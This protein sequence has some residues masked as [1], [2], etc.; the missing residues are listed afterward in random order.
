MRAE[1]ADRDDGGDDADCDDADEAD[2]ENV[3]RGE[4]ADRDQQ[5]Q[6]ACSRCSYNTRTLGIT[7]VVIIMMIN[8]HYNQ[9]SHDHYDHNYKITFFLKMMKTTLAISESKY[10]TAMRRMIHSFW[11]QIPDSS[12]SL[13]F[14]SSVRELQDVPQNVERLYFW[15]TLDHPCSSLGPPLTFQE[16]SG[17]RTYI[18]DNNS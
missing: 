16:V 3:P 7:I 1:L 8:D 15:T 9:G 14:Y 18:H 5:Q 4:L 11:I 10:L 12:D 13:C 17:F 6:E 2:D